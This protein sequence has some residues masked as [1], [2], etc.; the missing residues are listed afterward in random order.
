M[1]KV[2]ILAYDFPPYVSVGGLRPY[3]WYKYFREF[4]VDPVVITRHWENKYGNALDYITASSNEQTVREE[5][6]MGL[7][8][9]TTYKQTWSDR[10]LEQKGDNHLRYLR[11]MNTAIHE[12][13]QFFKISGP[14]KEIYMEA[15]NYLTQNKVDVI[16]ATGE[17]FVLFYFA[18]KLSKQFDV[19]WIADYRDLWSQNVTVKN[20]TLRWI[21]SLIETRIVK[22]ATS[23]TTVSSY[24]KHKIQLQFKKNVEINIIANGYNE[25]LIH[26]LEK[27]NNDK[28][29]VLTFAGTIYN[30][31]P[32]KIFL[33]AIDHVH[34][35]IPILIKF[36]GVNN[37]EEILNF[38]ETEKIQNV[39]FQ[40]IKKLSNHQTLKELSKSNLLFL[41]N[42][43]SI[44]GTKIFDYLA[45]KRK[46][47]LCF[48]DDNEAKKLKLKHF[49]IEKMKGISD[50]LQ[51]EIL[52]ETRAGITVTDSDHLKEIIIDAGKELENNNEISCNSVHI[53]QFSRKIQVQKLAELIHSM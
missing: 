33:K 32:W 34:I 43:Y 19:P 2:L 44:L 12:Y 7:I 38:I 30:W 50:S 17:P 23:I 45:V 26:D 20:K 24:L 10:N 13:K 39:K 1:K 6:P 31:H 21:N 51:S 46:I 11:K 49:N 53:N 18:S 8:L 36:I 9:R 35:T 42:D 16:I 47:I 37:Q 15:F 52:S 29:L 25:D 28:L 3:N 4:G 22:S 5:S 41:F 14:K 27:Q 48:S 40:F